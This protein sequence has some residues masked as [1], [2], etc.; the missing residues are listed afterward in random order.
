M[1]SRLL[2]QD[3]MDDSCRWPTKPFLDFSV[4]PKSQFR[5][6]KFSMVSSTVSSSIWRQRA[7]KSSGF[8]L[9]WGL[10][11][12][13]SSGSF[14]C[15]MIS[16]FLWPGEKVAILRPWVWGPLRSAISTSGLGCQRGVKFIFI[17][18]IRSALDL[19]EARNFHFNNFKQN[20]SWKHTFR[21]VVVTP[22]EVATPFS[23]IRNG[24]KN[25]WEKFRRFILRSSL[26]A[27]RREASQSS[28]EIKRNRAQTAKQCTW[29]GVLYL[30]WREPTSIRDKAA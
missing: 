18:F 23:L 5:D 20:K 11:C 29:S 2:T 27:H 3:V 10:E 21:C 15:R 25:A 14:C 30:I 9:G 24:T 7:P 4:A 17:V 19:L 28:A 1:A 13:C 16:R 8:V 6:C 12:A 22:W 26:V